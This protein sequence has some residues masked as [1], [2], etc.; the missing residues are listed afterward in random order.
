MNKSLLLTLA[1]ST[2]MLAACGG[3]NDSSDS[4]SSAENNANTA[5]V[6]FLSGAKG[7]NYEFTF[8]DI[9][10][11][12]YSADAGSYEYEG[13]PVYLINNKTQGFF[14]AFETSGVFELAEVAA[15]NTTLTINDF[16]G[17]HSKLATLSESVF[18][19][20]N[21]YVATKT[22]S[23]AFDINLEAD[24][25]S[26]AVEASLAYEEGD[27]DLVKATLYLSSS[28]NSAKL[29]AQ[30]VSGN[31]IAT[32]DSFLDKIGEVTVPTALSTWLASPTEVTAKTD[33]DATDKQYL[34]YVLGKDIPSF[35]SGFT[36]ALETYYEP[37]YD[38]SVILDYGAGIT[39]S[40]FEKWLTDVGYSKELTN[41]AYYN[42]KYGF[43]DTV[44]LEKVDSTKSNISYLAQIDAIEADELYPNG[45][46]SV[47]FTKV[48]SYLTSTGLE[49]VNAALSKAS[50]PGSNVF[51]P[52]MDENTDVSN[53]KLNDF[54][55]FQN[56]YYAVDT[57]NFAKIGYYAY[58]DWEYYLQVEA[59]VLAEEK[60]TAL[61]DT[62][63]DKLYKQGALKTTSTKTG[64]VVST[65]KTIDNTTLLGQWTSTTSCVITF[66]SS[67]KAT[68]NDG[69]NQFD[70]TY[71]FDS[72]AGSGTISNF[73]DWENST[74]TLA[75]GSLTVKL[76]DPHDEN[77]VSLT[78]TK[79]GEIDTGS[80]G[81]QSVADQED[82]YLIFSYT[83]TKTYTTY[84]AYLAVDYDTS[85]NY[86][87]TVT[88]EFYK[89][90]Y[91]DFV[92]I[93]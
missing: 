41:A 63:A 36:F 74:F 92:E 15:T 25:V 34:G 35:Y 42:E 90:E 22:Y 80:V 14:Y 83:D 50:L 91:T 78:C 1:V 84:V 59:S 18:T 70:I 60:A 48:V 11:T 44:F 38:Y 73:S 19:L 77:D 6:N 37:T 88:F 9:T 86:E 51:L 58:C 72:T 16:F 68:Y 40:A 81:V 69:S 33:W 52:A 32:I 85:G 89:L 76:E 17:G 49:T 87:G 67:G 66:Y 5:L 61:V 31:E 79:T 7:Y 93:S 71:T 56:Y 24:G 64:E 21:E 30:D 45:G 82:K 55:D 47:I 13:V 20:D 53:W 23:Y 46:A 28:G 10:Y 3:S 65:T 43:S 8:D 12:A 4:S 29:S 57:E 26:S 54:T 27:L 39:V 2:L 75:D 62:Y